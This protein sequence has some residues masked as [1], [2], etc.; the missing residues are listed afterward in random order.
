MTSPFADAPC[1]MTFCYALLHIIP[2]T[3]TKFAAVMV[4]RTTVDGL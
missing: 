3:S 2:P 1:F 4:F